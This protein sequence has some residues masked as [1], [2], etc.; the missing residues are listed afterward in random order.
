LTVY[1]INPRGLEVAPVMYGTSIGSGF[2]TGT[3]DPASGELVFESMLLKP[4]A[5]FSGSRTTL[6]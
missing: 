1:T 5:K 3:Q 4:A 2:L 6:T